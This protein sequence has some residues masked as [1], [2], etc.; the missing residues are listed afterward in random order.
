MSQQTSPKS[1]SVRMSTFR[2][3]MLD[4]S[5]WR[6][7]WALT[8]TLKQGLC[9]AVPPDSALGSKNSHVWIAIDEAQC[10][11][12]FRHFRNLL[13]RAVYGSAVRRHGKRLR[14]IDVVE[15]DGDVRWHIHAAIEPPMRL[16]AAEFERLIH[17]CWRPTDW[18]H[19]RIQVRPDA[20]QEWVAYMLKSSQKSGLENWFDCID[21]DCLHNPNCSVM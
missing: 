16:G 13:N 18:G 19:C 1:G 14:V 11:K 6:S 8:L 12:A 2:W 20:D 4:T 10:K 9:S 21:L 17:N 7:I 15:K 3:K 5:H